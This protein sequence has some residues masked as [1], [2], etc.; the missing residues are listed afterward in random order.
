MRG[1]VL[2]VLGGEYESG[3]FGEELKIGEIKIEIFDKQGR[4]IRS[5]TGQTAIRG[6]SAAA[7]LPQIR[8]R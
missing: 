1:A 2:E 7:K 8:Q 6:I 4:F 3:Y 5:S